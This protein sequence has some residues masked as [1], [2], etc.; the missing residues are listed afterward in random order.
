MPFHMQGNE[1]KEPEPYESWNKFTSFIFSLKSFAIYV[2]LKINLCLMKWLLF[3]ANTKIW[4]QVY[5]RLLHYNHTL[6]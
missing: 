3:A 1:T 6:Q 5:C 2:K 4:N